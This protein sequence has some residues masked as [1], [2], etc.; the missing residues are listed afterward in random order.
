MAPDAFLACHTPAAWV[1]AARVNPELLLIDHAN[2]EKKAAATALNLMFRYGERDAA[3]QEAMSRL[4]REELR[5]F[6]QVTRLMRKRGI[7]HQALGPSRYAAGLRRHVRQRDPE[8]LC[9]LLVVGAFIEARSCERF[10][11]VADTLDPELAG[12]YAGLAESEARHFHVYLELAERRG[13]DTAERCR[14]FSGV[15]AGLVQDP[16][17]VFRFHS[18]VPA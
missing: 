4:A 15:E 2:C 18:G 1:E 16:D 14:L 11:A 5:H 13:R 17:P 3:L 6:E 8:R 12:F 7:A 10:R 9:D